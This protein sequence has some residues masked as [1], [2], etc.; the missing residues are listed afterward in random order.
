MIGTISEIS[1]ISSSMGWMRDQQNRYCEIKGSRWL[2]FV[3][4]EKS[5]YE[6]CIIQIKE[7]VSVAANMEATEIRGTSG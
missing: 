6:V 2:L 4:L 1:F 3:F 5:L 7:Q